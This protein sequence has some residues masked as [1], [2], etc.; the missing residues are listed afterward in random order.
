MLP[1]QHK[2]VSRSTT[3]TGDRPAVSA[4]PTIEPSCK[5]IPRYNTCKTM[6]Q[7]WPVETRADCWTMCAYE[8]C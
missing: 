5:D 1:G 3:F 6:C 4:P 7:N 2:P 8:W